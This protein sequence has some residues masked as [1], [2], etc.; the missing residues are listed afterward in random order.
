MNVCSLFSW[1]RFQ[2]VNWRQEFAGLPGIFR[3]KKV[4]SMRDPR[5]KPNVIVLVVTGTLD[6]ATFPL[7]KKATTCATPPELSP[8]QDFGLQIRMYPIKDVLKSFRN[9]SHTEVV[10]N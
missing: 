2:G 10:N 4:K 8:A 1:F 6:G 9:T 7:S 5:Q 3:Q